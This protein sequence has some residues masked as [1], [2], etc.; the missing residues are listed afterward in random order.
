MVTVSPTFT[1][2]QD[3]RM[4][5]GAEVFVWNPRKYYTI[6]LEGGTYENYIIIC[7]HVRATVFLWLSTYLKDQP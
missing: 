6:Y 7:L 5:G 2:L 1:N 4:G 3:G